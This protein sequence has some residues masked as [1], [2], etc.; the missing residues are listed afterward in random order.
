MRSLCA[1]SFS[2]IVCVTFAC[3]RAQPA[4][5][6]VSPPLTRTCPLDTAPPLLR[7]DA[8]P[9]HEISGILVQASSSARVDR[10]YAIADLQLPTGRVVRQSAD[11]GFRFDSLR[12]GVYVLR[13]R[14]LAHNARVDTLSLADNT[15][16]RLTLP[17]TPVANDAC[18]FGPVKLPAR[19]R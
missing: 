18:G 17:L 4:T 13:V 5:A 15:G 19:H 7:I 8:G 9:P 6:S 11:G 12:A 1:I 10:A 3:R 16:L 2:I 14:A